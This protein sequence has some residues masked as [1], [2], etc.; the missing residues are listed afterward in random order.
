MQNSQTISIA[1][2]LLLVREIVNLHSTQVAESIPWPDADVLG[3]RSNTLGFL[4]R[5]EKLQRQIR[6]GLSKIE[7]K[8]FAGYRHP[9]A[10]SIP[11]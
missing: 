5:P 9:L 2:I 4:G 7:V 3:S 10:E 1:I 8:L 11:M 6:L